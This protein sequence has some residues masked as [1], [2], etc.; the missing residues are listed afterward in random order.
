M[1]SLYDL[2]PGYLTAGAKDTAGDFSFLM[3]IGQANV[4]QNYV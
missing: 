2:G 1:I 3:L 4:G